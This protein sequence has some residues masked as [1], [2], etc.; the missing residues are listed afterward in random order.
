MHVSDLKLVGAADEGRRE[1]GGCDVVEGGKRPA[2]FP[3][4]QVN[5]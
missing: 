4:D 2:W 5:H 3:S 1:E